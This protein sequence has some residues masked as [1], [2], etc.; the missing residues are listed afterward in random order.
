MALD[1]N[2]K[3]IVKA[4]QQVIQSYQDYETDTQTTTVTVVQA[5]ERL[6]CVLAEIKRGK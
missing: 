3:M 6:D 2:T 5:C 4:C 1:E